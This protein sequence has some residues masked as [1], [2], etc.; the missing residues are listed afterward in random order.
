MDRVTVPEAH[1]LD[2]VSQLGYIAARTEK[3]ELQTGILPMFS[4]TPTNL[5]MTAAGLDYISGGR[6]I[7]GIGASGPQVIEG[8]HGVPYNAPLGRAREHVEICRKVWRREP[9]AFDGK[10]YHLLLT[11]HGG[12]GLGKAQDH[13][14][15]RSET[16]SRCCWRPSA[17]RTDRAGR[18]TLRGVPARFLFHPE[19]VGAA[20]RRWPRA[21][22][23]AARTCRR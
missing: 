17:R 9:V 12:S 22:P 23:S 6:A 2:A 15:F 8:F 5:A 4:R 1:S 18:R 19:H 3:M 11:E 7:L 14:P 21:R 10:Y 16:G 13:Q 20:C